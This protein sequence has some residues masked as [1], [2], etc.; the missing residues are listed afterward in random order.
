MI[1]VEKKLLCIKI[2]YIFEE[3]FGPISIQEI[4]G[5]KEFSYPYPLL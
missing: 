1:G 3:L 2:C 4:L 5:L